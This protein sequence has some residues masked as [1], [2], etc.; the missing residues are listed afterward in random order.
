MH[1]FMHRGHGHG[2]HRG[3]GHGDPPDGG[4]ASSPRT[5][6][7]SSWSGNAAPNGDNHGHHG[8]LP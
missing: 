7:E 1:L 5:K 2:G 4:S 8:S 3:S 6:P